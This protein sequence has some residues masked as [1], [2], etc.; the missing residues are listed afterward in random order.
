MPAITAQP[1]SYLDEVRKLDPRGRLLHWI[2]ERE[3]ARL[4]KLK[5]FPKPWTNDPILQAYRFC[6]VRRMDDKV[7]QWLDLH[8]YTPNRNHKN[9]VIAC[10]LARHFNQPQTLARIGFP[11]VYNA[12]YIQSGLEHIEALKRQGETTFNSA[13]I[14]R[15]SGDYPNKAEMVFYETVQQFVDSP[16]KYL[17][18]ADRMEDAVNLLMGYRNIGSF[19]A[20]QIAA[21]LRWATNGKF[22]DKDEWAAMG[23]GS[24]RGINII[25]GRALEYP[26]KQE[27]FTEEL[28]NLMTFLKKALPS[29]LTSRLEAIDYQNCL[30]EYS[31][32]EKVLW[33]RGRKKQ[34]YDGKA[35]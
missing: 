30:C 31:G 13:Y 33:D 16:T 8:W 32:Y 17:S 20:G 10:V 27:Q 11:K 14:I 6:N 19:M 23:P 4:A 9:M 2:K 7:S 21:D 22:I 34:L 28:K 18:K 5:G 26:I 12:G 15:A 25:H 24:K 35:D 29:S 3:K 1:K